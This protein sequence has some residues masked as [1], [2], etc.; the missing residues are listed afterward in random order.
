MAHRLSR[1]RGRGERVGSLSEIDGARAPPHAL[2][3]REPSGMR[4]G[5][6]CFQRADGGGTGSRKAG[7]ANER[8][9]V[10]RMFLVRSWC[11]SGRILACFWCEAGETELKPERG[12]IQEGRDAKPPLARR[13]AV[14]R[15][16]TYRNA[17]SMHIPRRT[18][19]SSTS[20]PF[21]APGSNDARN[22][23]AMRSRSMARRS[24]RH[25]TGKENTHLRTRLAL[26]GRQHIRMAFSVL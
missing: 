13:F 8:P 16:D 11:V 4:R 1:R 21:P 6:R 17:R 15:T 12:A 23:G 25:R 24:S 18:A 19:A 2:G 14:R 9:H 5:L 10:A 3:H 20:T 26:R 7:V 22:E